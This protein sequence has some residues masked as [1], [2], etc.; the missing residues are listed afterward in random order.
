LIMRSQK[1][2]CFMVNLVLS[3]TSLRL[4]FSSEV[5]SLSMRNIIYQLARFGN[6]HIVLSLMIR[7]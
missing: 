3:F 4:G 7:Q 1:A 6:A 5:L 2:L